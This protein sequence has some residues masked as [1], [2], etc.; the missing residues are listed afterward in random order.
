MGHAPAFGGGLPSRRRD[1]SL[2]SSIRPLFPAG[3]KLVASYDVFEPGTVK[4]RLGEESSKALPILVPARLQH[5]GGEVL[6]TQHAGW[7]CFVE[8]LDGLGQ[9]LFHQRIVSG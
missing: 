1:E 9:R 8:R 4:L 3:F 6:G 5:D 2:R 7:C